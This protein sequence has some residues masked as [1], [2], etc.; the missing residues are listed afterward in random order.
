MF[1]FLIA[2]ATYRNT[3]SIVHEKAT[4]FAIAVFHII[5]KGLILSRV[6]RIRSTPE[7][8]IVTETH[9]IMKEFT[10]RQRTEASGVVAAWIITWRAGASGVV[11]SCGIGQSLGDV[12]RT[13]AADVIATVAAD[14]FALETDIVHELYPLS[15][16]RNMPAIRTN[17][18]HTAGIV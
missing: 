18:L 17:S 4:H 16:T 15:I 8:G 2:D 12:F 13:A 5:A 9:V 6:I 3:S 1:C 11:P 7:N 14:V 10:C